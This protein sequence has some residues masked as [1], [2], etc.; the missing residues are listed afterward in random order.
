VVRAYDIRAAALGAGRLAVIWRDITERKR[1]DQE[2][3]TQAAILKRAAEGVCM[4]RVDDGKIVYVNTRFAEILGYH[5]AE[6]EGV[7]LVDLG[8]EE[9]GEHA[10]WLKL[11]QVGDIGEVSYEIR[12]QRRD[13]V[14]I[15]LEGRVTAVDHP[16]H[17]DVWMI[18]QQD[19]TARREAAATL[20]LTDDPL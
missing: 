2:L 10:A 17:G 3:Q 7:R 19:V 20:A 8:W 15:W 1:A 18:V 12:A 4:V 6:L 13:G 5:V 9:E 11:A 16:E 14:A